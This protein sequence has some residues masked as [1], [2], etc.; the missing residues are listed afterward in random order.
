[1]QISP[2]LNNY[3]LQ[4]VV[5]F[6]ALGTEPAK[7]MIYDG[8]Q[9]AFGAA[10]AGNLLIEIPLVEPIG[11]ISN[12]VLAIAATPEAM[13]ALTGDATW[14]RLVNGDGTLG[15][16]CAVSD[17]AGNAPLRLASTTLYAGGYGRIVSGTII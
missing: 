15:W 2:E 4:G 14:A 9:P 12:G 8:A 5:D 7:A 1:M 10:P 16:D 6:F 13:V 3:R 17:M 11:A